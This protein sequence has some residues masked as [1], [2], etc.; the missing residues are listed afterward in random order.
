MD[1]KPIGLLLIEDDA[2]DR[3]L[4]Q[5]ALKGLSPALEIAVET[6]ESLA[7][8]LEYLQ[9]GNFGLVLLDLGLPDSSG[10]DSV[11][12]ICSSYSRLP[13]IVLTGLD[14]EQTGIEAIRTGASDYLVKGK[15]DRDFLS[16]IIRY[17]LERKQAEKTL[18]ES[19][20]KYKCLTESLNE[21]VYR[22]DPNTFVAT[23]VNNAVERFYGF[24]VEQWLREPNLWK[25]LIHPYDRE[26]VLAEFTEAHKE[27]KSAV[28]EYRIINKNKEVRWIEDRISWEKDQQGKVVSMNGIVY[29]ITERKKAEEELEGL[30]QQ[31]KATVDMLTTANLELADFAHIAAHD[32]KAPLRGIGSLAGMIS[33]EYSDKLD[34]QG[35][36]LLSLLV[37]RAERMYEQIDGILRYSEIGRV[38]EKKETVDLNK[39][40][41]EIISTMAL[42]E[43]IEISIGN[44]LPTLMCD[45]TR[46]KQVFQNLL[47]NAMKY[48][49]KPKG[50]IRV[51]CNEEENCWK[52]SISDNG[53]GIEEKYFEKIFQIFQ[54]LTSRDEVE[55]TGIGLSI[56]KKIVELY[57]GRIWVESESGRGSTFFFTLPKQE[58][59]LA[60]NAN[61]EV[62]I[63][64]LR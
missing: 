23:Y 36:E 62:D 59:E 5:L 55:A 8:G 17:S 22:A 44:E 52:F 57:G 13:V 1:G 38:P 9:D 35:R 60:D 33:T 32:L 19:E 29:D 40:I 53:Q 20:E 46:M 10:I 34:E 45:K 50:Q 2:G 56:V 39:L 30:N 31:L 37:G 48:I 14:D 47:D 58:S 6:A 3:K 28:I 43:N 12:R 24:S 54:M 41:N 51:D 4:I 15:I 42:P 64:S 63:V 25:D 11:Y 27:L 18:W 7:E 49:D 26:R 21:L 61:L 16:R